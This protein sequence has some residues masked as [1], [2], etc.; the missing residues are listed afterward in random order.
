MGR[1]SNGRVLAIKYPS[2]VEGWLD[3]CGKD[4]ICNM[5]T[6]GIDLLEPADEPKS[7]RTHFQ[8]VERPGELSEIICALRCISTCVVLRLLHRIQ[9]TA[10]KIHI[11][12]NRFLA[13]RVWNYPAREQATNR[14]NFR[15][16]FNDICQGTQNLH[17]VNQKPCRKHMVQVTVWGGIIPTKSVNWTGFAMGN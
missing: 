7:C 10:E 3:V 6:R 11:V 1:R 14:N 13:T 4:S 16:P 2:R 17:L 9:S 5:W 12:A 8:P 15:W